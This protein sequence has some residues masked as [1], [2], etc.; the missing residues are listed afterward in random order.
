MNA[1][2][3]LVGCGTSP[4]GLTDLD[5]RYTEIQAAL[6]VADRDTSRNVSNKEARARKIEHE[7]ARVAFFRDAAVIETIETA[8]ASSDATTAAKGEAY[9]R[10]AIFI[11]SWTEE[12]KE[13]ETELLASIEQ[14]RASDVTWSP[15]DGEPISL[16][17]RWESV[18]AGADDLSE[19]QRQELAVQWT[20]HRTSWIGPELEELIRLRNE[21]ARREG[22]DD[23]WQLALAHRGLTPEDV[24]AM[25]AAIAEL[26]APLNAARAERVSTNSGGL[27]LAN[28]FANEPLLRRQAGIALDPTETDG[29]FDSDMA[30]ERVATAMA[31]IG[32][33]ID[34]LQVYI[35]PTRFTRAGAYSFAIRP[36]QHAAIVVSSD[37][38]WSDWPYRALMHETGLAFWWRNLTPEAAASPPLWN[39]AT[40][41]FE[42][43]AEFFERMMFEPTW[44]ER[45]VPDVPADRRQAFTDSRR[46]Q[47]I[48]TLTWYLGCTRG[49]RMLYASPGE[50]ETISAELAVQEKALRGW[51][52]DPPSG[53]LAYTSFLQSGLM[54]NYPAYVQNFLFAS[55]TE[56]RLWDAATSAVG[57]P[58]ANPKLG[59]WLADEVVHKVTATH[60]L[61][62]RLDELDPNGPTAA[63]AAYLNGG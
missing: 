10:E 46:D 23:Y 28:T 4:D 40:P 51:A 6:G 52:S 35:G 58:V 47:T 45:Y 44:L 36:P 57:D 19:E 43:F 25:D 55:A 18:S 54:L 2:F 20:S 16:R 1:I 5:T 13:R 21:V 50:F 29:W 27:R 38:R 31:D 30:E 56:A 63:L 9:W 24:D 42:G 48:Q 60:S 34:G 15:E 11:R 49:E 53:D 39:P 61:A 32:S 3:L 8:R 33:P 62:E 14:S 17:G 22:F 59:P 12:E 7:Q 37:T 41:W 26:I